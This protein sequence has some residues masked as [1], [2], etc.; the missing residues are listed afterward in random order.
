M[1]RCFI[2]IKSSNSG[3]LGEVICSNSMYSFRSVR[4]F[5]LAASLF[6][7]T[8]SRLGA[9]VVVLATGRFQLQ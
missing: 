7:R 6:E 5:G 1:M 8:T 9:A 4:V 2:E 3:D